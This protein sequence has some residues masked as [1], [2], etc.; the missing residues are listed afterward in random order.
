V[1][2]HFFIGSNQTTAAQD[3]AIDKFIGNGALLKTFRNKNPLLWITV[4]LCVLAVMYWA[5]IVSDRYVSEA[6]VIIQQTDLQ[7]SQPTDL[8]GLLGVSG[9]PGRSDQLLLRD[10]LLSIDMLLKLDAELDLRGHYSNRAKDPISR[11]WSPDISIEW[12]HWYYLSRVS[13]ELDEYSGVLVIHAEAFTP[14]KALAI[15]SMLVEEGERYM[16]LMAHRLAQEQVGFIEKQVGQLSDRLMEARGAVLNYQNERNMVSPQG[17]AENLFAIVNQLEGQLATLKTQRDALL[18]IVHPKSPS[19]IDL[20]MQIA[21]VKKQIA[22]AQTRLTSSD[23]R[24]LNSA[25]EE[26]QRLQM[27]AEFAQEL[28]KTAL[29]ALERERVDAGRT[30]KMVSVLQQPTHPQYPMQP[31]R[32]YNAVVFIIASLTLAGILNLLRVIIREHRD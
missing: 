7:T 23:R 16:N 9:T 14:D 21:A 18:G 22:H 29:A 2:L 27:N 13:V 10:H 20:D 11:L 32:I 28:Y 15:A 25:I 26:F 31:R 19:V 6:H 30:L 3:A 5:V 17:T 24:T 12:F 8:S 4:A 1:A